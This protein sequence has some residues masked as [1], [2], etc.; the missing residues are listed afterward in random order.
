MLVQLLSLNLNICFNCLRAA[1]VKPTSLYSLTN[2]PGME[3]FLKDLDLK[4]L[5]IAT[6]QHI[7]RS[8]I[9][10]ERNAPL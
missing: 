5:I 3:I 4:K 6:A 8:C 1:G 10:N 7:Q 9:C 2:K